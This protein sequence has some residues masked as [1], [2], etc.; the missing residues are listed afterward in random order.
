MSSRLSALILSSFVCACEFAIDDHVVPASD[1]GADASDAVP[2]AGEA[3]RDAGTLAPDADPGADGGSDDASIAPGPTPCAADADCA[4]DGFC[5]Q[6]G[7][8]EARCD[9]TRGC[10]GPVQDRVA[11]QVLQDGP[12][13]IWA[14]PSGTD[15]VQNP[16]SDG[17]IYAWDGDGEPIAVATNL[18]SPAL[19]SVVDGYVYFEVG[20][21]RAVPSGLWRVR[22]GAASTPEQLDWHGPV[23]TV[24]STPQH[25]WWIVLDDK[26]GTLWRRARSAGASDESMR[27]LALLDLDQPTSPRQRL[28]ASGLALVGD[29][30]YVFSQDF[31]GAIY[32]TPVATGDTVTLAETKGAELC[33]LTPV[34]DDA[35]LVSLYQSKR[36]DLATGA[37][38]NVASF[39]SG[40]TMGTTVVRGDWVYWMAGGDPYSYDFAVTKLKLGRSHLRTGAIEE[41]ATVATGFVPDG[42]KFQPFLPPMFVG[43][44][45]DAITYY[46]PGYARFFTVDV[47]ALPCSDALACPNGLVCVTDTCQ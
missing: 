35:L 32:A 43:P 13:M 41:L 33:T 24:W 23:F 17:A 1:G 3:E 29:E 7:Q 20:G 27:S 15:A 47:A 11:L 4:A 25:L 28:T 16:S 9:A 14:R 6:N 46:D 42:G 36:L 12:R 37:Q 8:C 26:T 40:W 22:L 38:R 34:G 2:E 39:G 5:G 21:Y 45:G 18:D 30:R 10:A 19:I 44:K 31:F